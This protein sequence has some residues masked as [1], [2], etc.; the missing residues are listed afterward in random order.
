MTKSITNTRSEY[1]FTFIAPEVV[2][3]NELILQLSLGQTISGSCSLAVDEFLVGTHT[4]EK[5]DDRTIKIL[6][7]FD[8][9][10]MITKTISYVITINDVTTPTSTAPLKYT[11]STTFN[12]V[13]N[14][15][16]E[17]FYSVDEPFPLE[18]TITKSNN[19]IHE[20]C[21]FVTA[22]TP[23]TEDYDSYEL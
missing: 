11:L 2:I 9:A 16:F 10:L 17:K 6:M 12:S 21:N 23:L 19:T 8:Q 15:E 1:K 22:I 5:V 4:C 14:Q 13:T 20:D 7:D 18:A 3:D